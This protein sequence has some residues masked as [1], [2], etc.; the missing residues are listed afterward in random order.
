MGNLVFAGAMSHAP[1]IAA[2]TGAAEEGQRQRFLSAAE[3][4]RGRLAEARPD[5]LV[6]IAPDHFSNFFIDNMP[7]A[8]ITLNET[9]PGP[10]EDWLGIPKTRIPGAPALAR[11]ILRHAYASDIE[12]AFSEDVEL[13]HAVMLPLKLLTP[14]FDIPI[15]WIM[16][17]CQVPPLMSLKRSYALGKAIRKAIDESGLRVGV[18]GTGGLSHSPGAAEA[19][20][21]HP[22]FDRH[23]L[24][25]LDRNA[26]EE[27]LSL[28]NDRIDAAGFGTWEI[29]LWITALGAAH[30][31][32]PRTLAYEA[33]HA[34]DTG[35]AIAVYE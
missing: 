32:K 35:C 5:V 27:L 33:I 19:Q 8:C 15:V 26:V 25:L 21:L 3:A 10:V 7:A 23:F 24:S 20:Q 17:N 30:D 16:Q 12:P 6:V 2:F 18:V 9:Y 28:P 11:A 14:D 22:E 34:W 31:R 4:L 1:G 13:D 29:R